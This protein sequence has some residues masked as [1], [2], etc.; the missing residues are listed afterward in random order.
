MGNY[1]TKIL[2]WNKENYKKYSM[3]IFKD[4]KFY[5]DSSIEL[6]SSLVSLTSFQAMLQK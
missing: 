1:E 6:V 2:P 3:I 4:T 5:K